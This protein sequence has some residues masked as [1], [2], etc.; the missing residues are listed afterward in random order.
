[1]VRHT[2]VWYQVYITDGQRC[3]A[4]EEEKAEKTKDDPV[5]AGQM[6][7]HPQKAKK[8]MSVSTSLSS[9]C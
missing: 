8:A 1:M 6:Q 9:H 3:H 4:T 2:S 5:Q 7:K